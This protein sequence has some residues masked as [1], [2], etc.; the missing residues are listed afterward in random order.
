MSKQK[1]QTAYVR[2]RVC[3]ADKPNGIRYVRLYG[4]CPIQDPAP[5]SITYDWKSGEKDMRHTEAVPADKPRHAY[6]IET[7]QNVRNVKVAFAVPAS[8]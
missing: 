4:T 8:R 6:T 5:L 7:G 1:I 3:G 2:V